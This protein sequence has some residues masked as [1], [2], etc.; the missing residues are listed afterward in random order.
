M[1]K[2]LTGIRTTGSLHLGHYV[3]ALQN[4][5]KLQ[6]QNK[7][8]CFF[9]LADLQALTTHVQH[10]EML[11]QAIYDIALDWLSI[12]LDPE[13]ENVNFVLQSQVFSRY[14]LTVLLQMVAEYKRIMRNPTLKTE[15]EKQTSASVGFM[16]YPVDQVADIFMVASDNLKEKVLVPVGEDQ[17]PHLE[18]ANELAKKFNKKYQEIFPKCQGLVTEFPRLVGIDGQN[19]MSKS[20]GNSINLSD[21]SKTVREKV[22]KMYTDPNRIRA[23]DPGKVEGNPVFIY[24]DAFNPNQEEINDLKSRYRLGKVGDVEVKQKLYLA[25]ENFLN[26]IRERRL[27][28]DKTYI[29]DVI[30]AG[31]KK[32]EINCQNITTKVKKAMGL[33]F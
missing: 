22:F 28:F 33:T 13:K 25:L 16:T 24:H 21:N 32:A 3:G 1:D 20:L 26:P 2:I 17:L 6:D 10:P 19:K 15:L 14:Q 30:Y 8:E 7:Y 11:E 9:L 18:Y 31:S 23:T 4:W 29:R 5:K 12:G 27:K